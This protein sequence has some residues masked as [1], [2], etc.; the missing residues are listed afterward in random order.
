VAVA[1]GITHLGFWSRRVDVGNR[2]TG[3]KVDVAGTGVDDC[4][5]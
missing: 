3:G 4:G 1:S 5:G 2:G